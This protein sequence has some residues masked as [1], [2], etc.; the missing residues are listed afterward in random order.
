M[1]LEMYKHFIELFKEISK[2]NWDFFPHCYCAIYKNI[3]T[4]F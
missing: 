1:F 2:E 3:E 4:I